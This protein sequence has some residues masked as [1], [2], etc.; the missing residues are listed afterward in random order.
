[1]KELLEIYKAYIKVVITGLILGATL[2]GLIIIALSLKQCV[3][4]KQTNHV[5]STEIRKQ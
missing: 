1:M 5:Q 3:T 2:I 4:I